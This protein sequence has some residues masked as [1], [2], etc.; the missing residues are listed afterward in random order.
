M[1][2]KLYEDI[3][4][5]LDEIRPDDVSE[6]S[7]PAYVTEMF[8]TKPYRFMFALRVPNFMNMVQYS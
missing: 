5:D 3:L 1:N 4:D 8:D 2:K 7:V 6:E